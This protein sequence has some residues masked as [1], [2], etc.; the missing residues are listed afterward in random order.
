MY[1]LYKLGTRE[2]VWK[3]IKMFSH[4]RRV[5][6][7][8]SGEKGRGFNTLTVDTTFRSSTSYLPCCSYCC[9]VCLI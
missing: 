4:D 7:N 2:R 1:K 3:W 6:I 8:M 9:F 5:A